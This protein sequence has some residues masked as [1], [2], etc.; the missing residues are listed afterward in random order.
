MFLMGLW[1]G[2]GLGKLRP[3]GASRLKTTCQGFKKAWP[4]LKRRIVIPKWPSF[5]LVGFGVVIELALAELLPPQPWRVLLALLG[6]LSCFVGAVIF[7]CCR[8]IRPF[9]DLLGELNKW[10]AIG[11]VAYFGLM[12]IAIMAWLSYMAGGGNWP[13]PTS[14]YFETAAQINATLLV[15]AAVGTRLKVPAAWNDSI[16]VRRAWI[17]LGLG[18]ALIGVAAGI[19]GS[20]ITKHP[21]VRKILFVLSV[22]PVMPIV[23]ALAFSAGEQFQTPDPPTDDKGLD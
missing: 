6:L 23:L 20:V 11:D 22:S 17:L 21:D 16:Q 8:V 2:G 9:L 7:I 12:W 14:G 4:W 5:G 1:N 13:V 19:A 3:M 10:A 15:A 18:L